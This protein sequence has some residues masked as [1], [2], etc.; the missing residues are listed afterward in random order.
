MPITVEIKSP[1]WKKTTP[2]KNH[3]DRLLKPI[4]SARSRKQPNTMSTI[5]STSSDRSASKRSTSSRRSRNQD[6]QFEIQ[7]ESL[8]SRQQ[9]RTNTNRSVSRTKIPKEVSGPGSIYGALS[10]D[11]GYSHISLKSEAIPHT[12]QR[13]EAPSGFDRQQH[14]HNIKIIIAGMFKD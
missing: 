2:N 7:H 14:I 5:K 1:A 8:M 12:I 6:S 3:L 13:P 10:Y 4:N 9:F 11:S